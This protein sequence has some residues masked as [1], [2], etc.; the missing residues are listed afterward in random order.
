MMAFLIAHTGI[1]AALLIGL[2]LGGIVGTM[3][4][5]DWGRIHLLGQLRTEW[6]RAEQACLVF[7]E[8]S[9]LHDPT[10]DTE[11]SYRV[12]PSWGGR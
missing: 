10:D 2:I 9:P 12:D 8:F 11:N 5:W 6:R 1:M 3:L 7:G 4:G